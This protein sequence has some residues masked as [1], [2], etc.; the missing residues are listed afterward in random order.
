[1]PRQHIVNVC[2]P[3][4]ALGDDGQPRGNAGVLRRDVPCSIEALSGTE[5][6]VGGQQTAITNYTVKLYGDPERKIRHTDWLTLG[7][8]KFAVQSID[9]P[10]MGQLGELTLICGERH[11]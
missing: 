8:R 1:M 3:P 4:T 9:D 11:Q 6:D 2:C 7:P 5:S 10:S